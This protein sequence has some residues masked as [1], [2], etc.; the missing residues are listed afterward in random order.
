[1]SENEEY[2]IGV[3]EVQFFLQDQD[4]QPV[5]DEQ[6]KVKRYYSPKSDFSEM[7]LTEELDVDQLEEAVC[8]I[9]GK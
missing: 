1:M 7:G 9:C 8:L 5:E 2:S 4:G 3:W 6:G